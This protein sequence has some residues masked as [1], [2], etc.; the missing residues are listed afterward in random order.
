MNRPLHASAQVSGCGRHGRLHLIGIVGIVFGLSAGQVIAGPLLPNGNPTH[1]GVEAM[2]LGTSVAGDQTVVLKPNPASLI[3]PGDSTW[4]T[5]VFN[6]PNQPYNTKGND[7][8]HLGNFTPL[9]GSLTLT[10]YEA[11]TDHPPGDIKFRGNPVDVSDI[12]G[13]G[14]A[15]VLSQRH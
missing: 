10:D 15:L 12:T 1:N 5:P 4:L 8:W 7:I 11:W 14:A 2:V 3:K 9:D 6:I 13:G